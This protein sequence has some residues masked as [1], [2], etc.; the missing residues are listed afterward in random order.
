MGLLDKLKKA[1]KSRQQ[2]PAQK[3]SEQKRDEDSDE[4]GSEYTDDD[5]ERVHDFEIG[6]ED[7]LVQVAL[8]TSAQDYQQ[9]ATTAG[10]STAA[11][12]ASEVSY[13]YWRDE[14][15]DYTDI[16]CDG[17]FEP[18]GDFPE[19]IE[20]GEFPTLAQLRHVQAF[21]G[22]R[23]EVITVNRV[24]D[25]ELQLA[26]EQACAAVAQA[27]QFGQVQKL[28]ALAKYVSGR[29]GGPCPDE[30][31][32]ATEYGRWTAPI[33][34]GN[35]SV[36]LPV[37]S[38]TLGTSRHR[39]LLYKALADSLGL[40]SMLVKGLAQAGAEG[41]A[42]LCVQVN[43]L[44]YHLD[45]MAAPGT[46]TPLHQHL[47]I[48][49]P[50]NLPSFGASSNSMPAAQ[51]QQNNHYA[52]AGPSISSSNHY[53]AGAGP[54]SSTAAAC[55]YQQNPIEAF[56]QQQHQLHLQNQRNQQ[57][58]QQQPLQGLSRQ[59]GVANAAASP[60]H[61]ASKAPAAAVAGNSGMP[62]LI[63]FGDEQ[64]SPKQ[65]FRPGSGM[66][67]QHSGVSSQSSAQTGHL[68]LQQQ[69]HSQQQQRRGTLPD[70]FSSL[71]VA[72]GVGGCLQP[73]LGAGVLAGN[74]QQ[75]QRYRQ[76]QQQQKTAHP[77][78]QMVAAHA[79]WEIDPFEITL[80]QRI[81]I[82]SYGEV[83]KGIWRGTEVAVKKFLEQN[84]SPQLV[85]EFKDEVDIMARLRHP[86]V[87][88]FMGAIMQANQLAIVTQFIPRG[89]LF[90]LLHRSKG[91]L[92]PRRRLQMALDIARGMNYLHSSQPAIVH[93]DLKSPNLLVDRD[94]TVKVCDFGL[95]RVKSATFLTSRSH[96]GTP[97]WM[98]PEILR[99][100]PSDEKAD[101]YS[102]GVVL[103]ELVTNQE[104]W[105]GL[106]PMQVWSHL[107]EPLATNR[108]QAGCRH[109][110]PKVGAAVHCHALVLC[111]VGSSTG[112]RSQLLCNESGW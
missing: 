77:A 10:L 112:A 47:P 72:D 60:F 56:L 46:L 3:K 58:Y 34:E 87:V 69:Q 5:D 101:V 28:Q 81:G 32:L 80:G 23:R 110:V 62:D 103:Y 1:K 7:Y 99:N 22:D 105:T 63:N 97:E 92:D 20:K 76:Q 88:L 25:A 89:S 6:Q 70:M 65:S 53:S 52:G 93:R 86:N 109:W 66:L 41:V 68:A 50:T 30:E 108:Q 78:L 75:Q 33:K 8:A 83:Y 37:G 14:R 19:I 55:A 104:P 59:A 61:A 98:A 102:Y 57:Q 100:E 15:L 35:K 11:P 29:L 48:I 84:L 79:A 64:P 40:P 111:V 71:A 12:G 74:Q 85:Q 73:A 49:H 95:S 51:Q 90:R 2:Q 45:L 94:W 4:F 38:L 27:A 16:I 39:A 96:G 44:S 9:Q 42:L 26:E 17:F 13:K 24:A 54:S 106:N 36:L 21:E 18:V 82:G 107:P 67:S 91:D 43:G 31:Q